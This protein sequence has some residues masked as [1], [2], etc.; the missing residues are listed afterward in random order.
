MSK[1]AASIHV[2]TDVETKVNEHVGPMFQD[3]E[4]KIEKV[5][6]CEK[7]FNELAA[8]VKDLQQT[9]A[10]MKSIVEDLKQNQSTT[11]Q[12]KPSTPLTQSTPSTPAT[13]AVE[14]ASSDKKTKKPSKKNVTEASKAEDNGFTTA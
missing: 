6:I 13:S 8:N 1:R 4:S 7:D 9:I 2:M 10:E 14:N 3:L 5:A 12:S 11:T